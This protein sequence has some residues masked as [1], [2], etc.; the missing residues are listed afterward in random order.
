MWVADVMNHA[1]E[2]SLQWRPPLQVLTGQTIDI[3][4]LLVFM[5]W[6]VVC[7]SRCDDTSHS[8]Q[9][10]SKKSSEIHGRFVGFAWNVGHR[11]TFKVLTDD[12]KRVVCC[13]RVRLAKDGENNLKLD[14]E[15]GEVPQRTFIKSKHDDEGD[16]V[17]LPTM[18]L[19]SDPF[20]DDQGEQEDEGP[21]A[22]EPGEQKKDK[23]AQDYHSDKLYFNTR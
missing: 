8:G 5:F 23:C 9:I 12:T 4:A 6:D 20:D 3:S 2:K 15:A 13:S 10:G 21:P 22:S 11:L 1:S 19:S 7:V 16:S 14:T 17:R 18:D